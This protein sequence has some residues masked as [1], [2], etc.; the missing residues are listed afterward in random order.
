MFAFLWTANILGS[1]G[2]PILIGQPGDP[3]TPGRDGKDGR[4][5]LPGKRGEK[6]Q[7]GDG[8]ISKEYYNRYYAILV[9]IRR[10]LLSK[11]CCRSY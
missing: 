3:G 1:P 9:T 8:D 2:Y 6:G 4:P 11:Q 10:V 7:K 5:G